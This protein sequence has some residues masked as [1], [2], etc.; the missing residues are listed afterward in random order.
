MIHNFY[1]ALS[2]DEPLPKPVDTILMNKT[3]VL[4]GS[5]TNPEPDVKTTKTLSNVPTPPH[6]LLAMADISPPGNKTKQSKSFENRQGKSKGLRKQFPYQR[7]AVNNSL[8]D[9]PET[10]QERFRQLRTKSVGR[11]NWRQG[12]FKSALLKK[13]IKFL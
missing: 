4:C 11:R 1:A 10:L 12:N 8:E 7:N 2:W 9:K 3:K 5:K 13:N 6:I